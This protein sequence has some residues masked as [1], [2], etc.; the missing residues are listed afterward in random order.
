MISAALTNAL[1][2][3]LDHCRA[4]NGAAENTVKAYQTDVLGFL[5]FMSAHHGGQQGLGPLSQIT[6][7]DMRAWMAA[8]RSR[9]VGA[10][11]LARAICRQNLLPLAGDT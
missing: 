10:R 1:A 6:I 5:A 7:S 11:S 8:E 4:L 2:S 9:G 3:W